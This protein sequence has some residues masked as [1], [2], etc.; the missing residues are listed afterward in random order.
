MSIFNRS[1]SSRRGA[2][3]KMYKSKLEEKKNRIGYVFVL[4]FIIGLVCIF[5]PTLVDSIIY[6]FSKVTLSLSA[7][8][9]ENVGFAN[10]IK[11][12]TVD[13][14]FRVLLLSAIQGMLLD[15]LVI[16]IFSFFI[17]ALL[18]QKFIGRSIARTIFFLPV[19]LATGIVAAADTNSLM[20]SVYGSATNDGST[21]SSAF[22]SNGFSVLF[23]LEDLLQ[24]TNLNQGAIQ[25][26]MG[27]VDNTYNIV[28]SSGVQILI[29]LSALQSISPSVFESARIE[30]ATKWE[31]FWK[32]T[33]PMITPMILV[34]VIYTV[35]DAFTNPKYQIL[36]YIQE[37]AFSENEMG[38]ASA[39]SW[40]YFVIILV[41]L[42]IITGVLSRRIHYLD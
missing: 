6:A 5:L 22:T 27:A 15:I 18:N 13:T 30:G 12:F 32:I 28:N 19:L 14:D 24:S 16:T 25:V 1:A 42:G 20:M 38:F 11:A 21:I 4:P 8:N 10:F 41:L 39:L 2:A 33:F 37:Q 40:I 26:I 31:E 9:T 3:A 36:E 29:F 35:V 17:A 7:V 23:S 34:N